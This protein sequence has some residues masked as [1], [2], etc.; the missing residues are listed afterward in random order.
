MGS[1]ALSG[2]ANEC[3]G[4]IS[5]GAAFAYAGLLLQRAPHPLGVP[6]I[7][8]NEYVWESDTPAK[9]TIPARAYAYTWGW[10]PDLGWLADKTVFRVEPK[11]PSD[12]TKPGVRTVARG[13]EL[14]AQSLDGQTDGYV[15]NLFH[16]SKYLPPHNSDFGKKKVSFEV[17]GN[18]VDYADVEVFYPSEANNHPPDGSKGY[19]TYSLFA[20]LDMEEID[21]QP[22][23]WFY[24]YW[25]V[26]GRPADVFYA[27]ERR[28]LATLFGLTCI[29]WGNNCR[30]EDVRIYIYSSVSPCRSGHSV[31]LFRLEER[32]PHCGSSSGSF[33]TRVDEVLYVYGIHKFVEVL[34]HELAHK[35]HALAVFIAHLAVMIQI[36]MD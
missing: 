27:E 34:E 29:R 26:Y 25:D 6:A 15:D 9:L 12:D 14:V 5:V 8:E 32:I 10:E 36:M 18:K 20:C 21:E 23:N 24:Y 4:A 35:R 11:I 33:I 3:A 13:R 19:R 28:G 31:P 16:R 22:P 2:S 17:E 30:V 1:T 7:G